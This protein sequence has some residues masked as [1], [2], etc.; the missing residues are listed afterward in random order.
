M[1]TDNMNADAEN[2]IVYL[3]KLLTE[4]LDELN[5][6]EPDDFSRGEMTAYVETLEVL[7]GW[8][9]AKA[10]GLNFRIEDKYKI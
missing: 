8:K 10:H 9:G 2:V 6:Y 4:Y 1:N 5:S 3:I 7:Q